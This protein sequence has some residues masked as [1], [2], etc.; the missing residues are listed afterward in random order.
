MKDTGKGGRGLSAG[1][2]NKV[3]KMIEMKYLIKHSM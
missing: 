2:E 3:G 1:D